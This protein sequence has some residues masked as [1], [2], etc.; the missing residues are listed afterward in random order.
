MGMTIPVTVP[1]AEGEQ[2]TRK[3]LMEDLKTVVVDAEELLRKAASDQTREWIGAVQAKAKKSLKVVNDW[4]SEEESAMT[5]KAKSAAKAA[6]DTI[7]ANTWMVLGMAAI[8]G[9]VVGILAVRRG[10][11]GIEE[12]EGEQR[13]AVDPFK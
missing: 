8:A 11:S 7:R 4:L 9:I 6:E 1:E 5:T 10:L 3:K 2:I 13:S 12:A